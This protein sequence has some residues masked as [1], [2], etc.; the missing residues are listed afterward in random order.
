MASWRGTQ[1]PA[2]LTECSVR[3][4]AAPRWN[5]FDFRRFSTKAE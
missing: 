5:R 2:R 1:M 3:R 4:G